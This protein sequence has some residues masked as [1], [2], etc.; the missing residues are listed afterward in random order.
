MKL[1]VTHSIVQD[2]TVVKFLSLGE[3]R[4]C[5]AFLQ[6]SKLEWTPLTYSSAKDTASI[7]VGEIVLN[8]ITNKFGEKKDASTNPNSGIAGMR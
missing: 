5:I 4:R 6:K 1:E 2:M 3:Y 8:I 7:R